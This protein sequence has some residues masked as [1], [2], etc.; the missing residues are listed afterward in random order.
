MNN[1]V[2]PT[3]R[4]QRDQRDRQADDIRVGFIG[5]LTPNKGIVTLGQAATLLG[6]DAPF[7]YLIAGRGHPE[8]VLELQALFP[9]CKTKFLG[10]TDAASFYPNIDVL[11]VPSIWAEPFGRVA[12]EALSFGVPLIVSR[13]GALPQIVEQGRSGFVFTPGDHEGLAACLSELAT[14][15]SLLLQ[16]RDAAL[17]RAQ[18]YTPELLALS[19]EGFLNEIRAGRK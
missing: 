10:W 18:S 3:H 12:I 13:T 8:F 14:E 16:L 4:D 11:V 2:T 17:K 9:S 19:L 5:L 15:R 6:K 7:Q 1:P